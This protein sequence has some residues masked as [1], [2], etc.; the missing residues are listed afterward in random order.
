MMITRKLD[1]PRGSGEQF[2]GE[3]RAV[4][5]NLQTNEQSL[6]PAF[7][8]YEGEKENLS[9]VIEQSCGLVFTNLEDRVIPTNLPNAGSNA[10]PDAEAH[11][12]RCRTAAME[13]AWA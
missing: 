3:K 13:G 10:S 1:K 5:M 11:A 12:V 9:L 6:I 7:S 2:S 4:P 8:P